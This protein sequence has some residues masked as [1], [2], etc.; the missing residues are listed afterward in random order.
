MRLL[1]LESF[2]GGLEFTAEGVR[3]QEVVLPGHELVL[4]VVEGSI[5]VENQRRVDAGTALAWTDGPAEWVAVTDVWH[6]QYQSVSR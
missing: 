6:W 4:V 3:K 1:R 2:S 5:E